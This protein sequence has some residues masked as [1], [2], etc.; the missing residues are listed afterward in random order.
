MPQDGFSL[1]R[2]DDILMELDINENKIFISKEIYD[3]M[4]AF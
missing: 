4:I 1:E 2:K 3:F